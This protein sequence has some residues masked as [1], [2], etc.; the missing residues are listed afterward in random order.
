MNFRFFLSLSRAFLG[1]P[2]LIACVSPKLSQ[3][4]PEQRNRFEKVRIYHPPRKTYY[5]LYSLVSKNDWV[6]QSSS[7]ASGLLSTAPM[8]G[9]GP[10]L[11]LGTEEFLSPLVDY[12]D[13]PG[14]SKARFK[15]DF[16]VSGSSDSLASD[17]EVKSLVEVQ[18]ST[19]SASWTAV[20]PSMDALIKSYQSILRR[21]EEELLVPN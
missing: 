1:F 17:L 2:L 11:S 16:T 13:V 5:S 3:L 21:L 6:I 8:T 18:S 4:A 10:V 12:G 20:D 9:E 15:L 7:P 14:Y 19:D